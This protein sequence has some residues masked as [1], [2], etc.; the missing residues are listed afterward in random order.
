MLRVFDS[1]EMLYLLEVLNLSKMVYLRYLFQV[2][3]L[4]EA[5]FF[6]KVFQ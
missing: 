1:L 6:V 5:V 3:S 2:F 4:L